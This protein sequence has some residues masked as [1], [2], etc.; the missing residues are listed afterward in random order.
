MSYIW[1]PIYRLS[2]T[3]DKDAKGFLEDMTS[4]HGFIR[5]LQCILRVVRFGLVHAGQPCNSFC[6]V[7]SASHGRSD[8]NSYMGR[9]D[10]DWIYMCNIIA[11]RCV[12]CLMVAFSRRVFFI[13][14]NPRQSQLPNFPYYDYLINLAERLDKHSLGYVLPK[15]TTWWLGSI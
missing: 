3:F 6:W 10:L 1:R 12:I 11:V 5:S 13:I 2:L 7:S 8:D 9:T 15:L 14:E 4:V